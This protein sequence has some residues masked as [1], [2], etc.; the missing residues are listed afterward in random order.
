MTSDPRQARTRSS[1]VSEPDQG[2]SKGTALLALVLIAVF[3]YAVRWAL[4]PFVVSAV[5]AYLCTPLIERFGKRTRLPRIV[6]VSAIF[7]ALLAAATTMVI[8]AVPPLVREATSTVGDLGATIERLARGA[9]GDGS[10]EFLGKPMNASEI[11]QAAASG[12]RDW[13]DQTGVLLTLASWSFAGLFGSFLAWVLFF[14]FLKDGPRLARGVLWLVPPR[15][16]PVTAFV[17]S[18]LDP[19]LKRYFIGVIVVVLYAMAAAYLG[20]GLLLGIRHAVFL[21][22]LTGLLE[23]IPVIGPASA[24]VLAG[25]VALR[26]ADSVASIVAYAIYATALRLSIDQ[27]LGPVVL[28]HAARLH[29]SVIIFC[30]L[31]GGLLF[32]IPGV[33]MAVP[34]ALAIKVGLATIYDEPHLVPIHVSDPA[35]PK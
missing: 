26:Q 18:R 14:F 2:V 9:I 13:L 12:L 19:V 17:W 31:A 4:L 10:I 30:F 5:G 32:G 3:L 16:R 8:I 33:I 23:M 20:L 24:A 6:F 29:P 11:A 21:A 28:G 35:R 1:D 25:L 27:L 34:V 7:I 22:V 15:N